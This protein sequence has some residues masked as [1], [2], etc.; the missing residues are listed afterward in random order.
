MTET[1][2]VRFWEH[3]RYDINLDADV[4]RLVATTP[5]GSWSSEFQVQGPAKTREKREAFKTYVVGAL[6]AGLEPCEVE[7]G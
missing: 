6:Q 4:I 5:R 3:E 1:F 2:Y 7:I